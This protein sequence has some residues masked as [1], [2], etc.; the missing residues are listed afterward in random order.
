MRKNSCLLLAVLLLV[1]AGAPRHALCGFARAEPA[2]EEPSAPTVPPAEPSEALPVPEAEPAPRITLEPD[3]AVVMNFSELAAAL[4]KN[5]GITKIYF[6]ADITATVGGATI[7]ASK[8]DVMVSGLNPLT[9]EQTQPFTLTDY[10]SASYSNTLH[11]NSAEIH[12]LEVRD[13]NIVGKN[14]YGSF[15]VLASTLLSGVT[16]T[17][18]RVT[19]NGPQIAHHPYGT[20]SF[21]DCKVTIHPGN[22]GSVAQEVSEAKHLRFE[23]E[24]EF[25]IGYSSVLPVFYHTG[26]GTFTLAEGA[27]V[28]VSSPKASA[29]YG[30]FSCGGVLPLEITVGP[31]A[32]FDIT[33][34][35]IVNDDAYCA[36]RN[37]TVKAGGALRVTTTETPLGPA[38]HMLG[39]LTVEEGAIFQ[40]HGHGSTTHALLRQESGD[41]T[42]GK[43]S[44]FH[45]TTDAQYAALLSLSSTAANT[46]RLICDDPASVLLKSGGRALR[47]EVAAGG[48]SVSAQ[49]I[50]YWEALVTEASGTA[51]LYRWERSDHSLFLLSAGLAIGSSGEFTSVSSNYT[52]PDPPGVPP[53]SARLSPGRCRVLALGRLELSLNPIMGGTQTVTGFTAPGAAVQAVLHRQGESIPLP[54]V[55]ADTEGS[56]HIT[57]GIVLREGDGIT[58]TGNWNYLSAQAEASVHEQGHLAL[59]APAALHFGSVS[60]SALPVVLERADPDWQLTVSDTRSGGGWRLY[61]RLEQELTPAHPNL[62][63]LPGAVVFVDAAG[64]IHQL[65]PGTN[66]LIASGTAAESGTSTRIAWPPGEGLLL[67]PPDSAAYAGVPYT[68]VI[69]WILTDAP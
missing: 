16:V 15:S 50:N 42:V 62:P 24:N 54:A 51:P 30:I 57:T 8:K 39:P 52:S 9:P 26:G 2:S 35:S 18:R 5:N 38:L 56:F 41:I 11:I 49:Q 58:V 48:L 32:V 47:A 20:V 21:I 44:V 66:F 34:S 59:S 55:T 40:M 17:Y 61:I 23:G 43:D 68:A 3:E 19:Y 64:V 67:S 28:T 65:A 63:N 22:G 36:I 4:S 27:R 33:V 7:H 29:A 13:L 69:S 46:R 31:H 45:L 60:L 37:L 12:S 1:T 10:S 25:I 14:Y 6:G 53:D